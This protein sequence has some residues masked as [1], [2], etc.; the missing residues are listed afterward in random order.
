MSL[1]KSVFPSFGSRT[2]RKHLGIYHRDEIG[3]PQEQRLSRDWLMGVF[4]EIEQRLK[5][6]QKATPTCGTCNRR[7]HLKTQCP[8]KKPT[9]DK[10]ESDSDQT[11]S[12]D[13]YS[14]ARSK[15]F[16]LK[17]PPTPFVKN[18]AAENV[19]FPYNTEEAPGESD[20]STE[21]SE[22]LHLSEPEEQE[23]SAEEY[24]PEGSSEEDEEVGDANAL[25]G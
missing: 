2:K 11:S 17:R 7:G 25:G 6:P 9:S 4:T 22:T 12:S 1:R 8:W 19:D 13:S 15:C 10:N 18:E 21:T 23:F 3:L 16:R 24:S 14:N 20:A 5:G